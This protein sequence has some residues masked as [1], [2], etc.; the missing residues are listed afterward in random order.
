LGQKKTW[1]ILREDEK[2]KKKYFSPNAGRKTT[3]A[4]ER[5]AS[6][7]KERETP[8]PALPDRVKKN[9]KIKQ[10]ARYKKKKKNPRKKGWSR[11][12]K[13]QTERL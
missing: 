12:L 8:Q 4:Y 6:S 11:G 9:E 3:N 7:K 5:I 13:A 10:D 2:E 1:A